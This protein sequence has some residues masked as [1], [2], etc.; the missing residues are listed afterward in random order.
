MLTQESSQTPSSGTRDHTYAK[1]AANTAESE[2]VSQSAIPDVA[3]KILPSGYACQCHEF[4]ELPTDSFTGAPQNS[5]YI[6][7]SVGNIISKDDVDHWLQ[8]FSVSSNMKYSAQAGYKRKGVKILYVGW[9]IF[10]CK[11]KAAKKRR[12]KRHSTHRENTGK[13]Q[14]PSLHLSKTRQKK[15]DCDSKMVIR[16][17]TNKKL[18]NLCEI[19]LWWNHNHSVDCFHLTSFCPILPATRD[20]FVTYFE[21]GMTASGAFH[22]HETQ[23]MRDPV[24]VMLLAD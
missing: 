17:Y 24:K 20:K 21:L 12:E 3:E 11:Q 16:I 7:I 23:L 9:Y 15:T 14:S 19:E 2:S 1:D 13:D 6:K 5:F 4:K 10:Q 18:A 22:H 8:Q